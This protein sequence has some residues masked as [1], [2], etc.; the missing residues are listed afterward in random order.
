MKWTLLRSLGFHLP[1]VLVGFEP[2][3]DADLAD[4][5]GL[6]GTA[7]QSFRLSSPVG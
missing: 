7:P 1:R 2:R 3:C 4:K 6:A 5:R